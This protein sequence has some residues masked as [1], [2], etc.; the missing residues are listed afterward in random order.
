MPNKLT[1]I[2]SDGSYGWSEAYYDNGNQGTLQQTLNAGRTLANLRSDMLAGANP[3]GTCIGPKIV[4][5][6]ASNTANPRYSL[7]GMYQA[8]TSLSQLKGSGGGTTNPDNPYSSVG[9]VLTNDRGHKSNRAISGVAD[10]A[11]SDQQLN[12]QNA[13]FGTA[14]NFL[15][16]LTADG[17][18]WGSLVPALGGDQKIT[19]ITQNANG[20]P[21]LTLAAALAPPGDL[22]SYLLVISGYKGQPGT[23]SIN[24][25]F[26]YDPNATNDVW[27]GFNRY[28]PLQPICMGLARLYVAAWSKFIDG[29]YSKPVKKNRGRPS[30]GPRGRS[31]KKR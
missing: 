15:S 31:R 27:T 7:T 30:G 3:S 19:N 23:P 22:C 1:M 16:S 18:P 5:L 17:G 14:T 24:G 2:F 9:L 20:Q 26:R 29:F 4:G 11:I 13:F 28:A 21:I 8:G 25:V 10:D 12:K 6:R